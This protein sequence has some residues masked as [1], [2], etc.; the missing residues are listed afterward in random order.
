MLRLDLWCSPSYGPDML[1]GTTVAIHTLS[2]GRANRRPPCLM[3]TSSAYA[4]DNL[5]YDTREA[6]VAVESASTVCVEWG[7]P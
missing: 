5:A 1:I 4:A 6:R 3:A 7:Y 2:D